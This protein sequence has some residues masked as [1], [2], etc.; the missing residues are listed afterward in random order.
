M[1]DGF[2]EVDPT[3][4]E[5]NPFF[6]SDYVVIMYKH[7]YTLYVVFSTTMYIVFSVR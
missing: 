6:T 7:D 4:A 1:I 3:H 2:I 5:S